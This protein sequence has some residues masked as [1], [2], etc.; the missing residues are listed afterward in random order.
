MPP[1]SNACQL[2][3]VVLY[4][5]VCSVGQFH[6]PKR[7]TPPPDVIARQ[8]SLRPA[9]WGAHPGR[10]GVRG[11][12]SQRARAVPTWKATAKVSNASD[13][14]AREGG[15]C[16][17]YHLCWPVRWELLRAGLGFTIRLLFATQTVRSKLLRTGAGFVD[18]RSFWPMPGTHGCC[19]VLAQ[20]FW[21][22][23]R[24]VLGC[25]PCFNGCESSVQLLDCRALQAS[26][27]ANPLLHLS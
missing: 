20:G 18:I 9:A 5:G 14:S 1:L 23:A 7:T 4:D 22:L 17:L 16:Q 11:H 26:P 8:S 15:A 27:C 19:C 3:P 25:A 12:H 13:A 6:P 10:R 24:S 21:A 2:C